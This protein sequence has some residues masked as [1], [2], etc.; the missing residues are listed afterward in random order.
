MRAKLL[1]IG[2]VFALVSATLG[3]GAF[4]S[5]TVDRQSNVNVVTD[6]SGLVGLED[7]TSGP[8]IF[9]NTS[10]ALG[11]DLSKASGSGANV[12]AHFEF[13][14]PNDPTN[15]S[16][17]NITNN[18]GEQHTFTLDYTD[19]ASDD[20]DNEV[21]LK[22]EV[23]D[24]SGTKLNTLTDESSAKDVTLSAGE[25]VYVVMIIDTEADKGAD[26]SGTLSITV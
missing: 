15:S 25:T 23:Y 1:A 26:Y 24:S 9:Q 20:S 2:L 13:G 4:T 6:D 12:H 3:V 14:D 17:F 19:I 18:D 21:D 11:I 16:A 8:L 7:G 5:A 22:F 10:G